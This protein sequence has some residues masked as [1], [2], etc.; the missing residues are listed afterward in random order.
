MKTRKFR[1]FYQTSLGEMIQ[2]DSV[3]VLK[4]REAN[5]VELIMTSPPFALICKKEYDNA[6]ADVYLDWF[7]PFAEQFHRV[8]KET[9]SLVIDIGGVWKNGQPTRSLYHFKLLIMLCEEM[10]FHLAQDLYWWNPSRLP[11]PTEW[12]AIRRIRLK[13]AINTIWWLSKTPWPKASNRR[14]LQPYST[15][16]NRWLSTNHTKGANQVRHRFGTRFSRNNGAAI[17]PNLIAL[18]SVANKNPYISYCREKGLSAHPTPFPS[19]LPEYFVRM[20]TDPG[21][22]VIDPFS[23][24]CTTGE[25]CEKLNR[26]WQCIDLSEN[27]LKGAVGRFKRDIFQDKHAQGICAGKKAANDSGV[28]DR[29]VSNKGVSQSEKFPYYCIPK[30]GIFWDSHQTRVSPS[31]TLPIDGGK[32]RQT[33][34]LRTNA[35]GTNP[36]PCQ[37]DHSKIQVSATFVSTTRVSAGIL[38]KK[39]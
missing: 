20:L 12:V 19:E 28:S 4:A 29:H 18:P 36:F 16:M 14:V 11:T 3:E 22:V 5:T 24:S 30:P 32:Q 33:N 6:H 37:K 23:G 7:R 26:R 2:G 15:S 17:P 39:G 25:V 9:G 31:D 27:Y 8:L 34:L 1:P 21:D 10:G 38:R 35:L 13:D